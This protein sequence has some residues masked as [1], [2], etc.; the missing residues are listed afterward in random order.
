MLQ[1][2][3]QFDYRVHFWVSVFVSTFFELDLSKWN[4]WN[5]YIQVEGKSE[6][7]SNVNLCSY[8]GKRFYVGTDTYQVERRGPNCPIQYLQQL[9]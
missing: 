2:R 1:F 7:N 3:D 6:E 9:F 8:T 4:S 5:I